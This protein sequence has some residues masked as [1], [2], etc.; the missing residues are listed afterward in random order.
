MK[1]EKF[2]SVRGSLNLELALVVA[3]LVIVC[4]VGLTDLGGSVGNR[5]EN[6]SVQ[7][8]GSVALDAPAFAGPVIASAASGVVAPGWVTITWTGGRSPFTLSCVSSP[9]DVI[10][11]VDILPADYL[12]IIPDM[13][14]NRVLTIMPPEDVDKTYIVT[15]ADGVAM[16]TPFTVQSFFRNFAHILNPDG[17]TTFTWNG[18]KAPFTLEL[19]GTVAYVGDN[20][21]Y[22]TDGTAWSTYDLRDADGSPWL[23]RTIANFYVA[24]TDIDAPGEFVA[25]NQ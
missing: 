15:D 19:N 5:L 22:T 10:E 17:S 1:L 13:D 25:G 2:N 3:L 8:A 6:D 18:G 11:Y 7:V 21:T 4:V 16:A 23:V 14:T 20:R 9:A 12:N 24:G